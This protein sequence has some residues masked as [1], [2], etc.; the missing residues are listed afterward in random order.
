MSDWKSNYGVSDQGAW[1]AGVYGQPNSTWD[2]ARAQEE[3]NKLRMSQAGYTPP[4][5]SFQFDMPPTVLPQLYYPPSNPS[6]SS[7][8]G[9]DS[10]PS[11]GRFRKFLIL[12][13]V[14]GIAGYFAMT[15]S[16]ALRIVL[17]GLVHTTQ[18]TT[19]P[20]DSAHYERLPGGAAQWA[21]QPTTRLYAAHFKDDASDWPAMSPNQQKAVAAAW[22]R[23]TRNPDA[24]NRLEATQKTFV[25]NTFESYLVTLAA[26]GDANA[27][28]DIKV[29]RARMQR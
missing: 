16:P 12:L 22:I 15:Q 14:L 29:L 21:N 8:S 5:P 10:A 25:F 3:S 17:A 18:T 27:A 13:V 19:T 28:R 20:L 6:Y 24:F 11:S 2:I 26:R 23:F 4:P 1:N 9:S 7:Y